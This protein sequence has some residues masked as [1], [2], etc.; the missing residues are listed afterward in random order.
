M[1]S[2]LTDVFCPAWEWWPMN[3]PHMR[4]VAFSYSEGITTRDNNKMTRLVMSRAYRD[5]WGDR[6]TMIKLGETKIEN[7]QTGYKLA[8]SVG[9]RG[10]GER[11][12][13]IRLDD[14]TT[15]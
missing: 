14:P 3:M 9:G 5:Q 4:Y 6:F 15:W 2:L 1:K 11:G 12:D 10:T 8:T 13:R 7:D